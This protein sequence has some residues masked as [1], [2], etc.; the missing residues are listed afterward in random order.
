M[1]IISQPQTPNKDN[2]SRF[3]RFTFL[4][5]QIFRTTYIGSQFLRRWI[6]SEIV[7]PFPLIN[8]CAQGCVSVGRGT[9]RECIEFKLY[10]A[11]SFD[12]LDKSI[13][14][15]CEQD[16]V[17]SMFC[18]LSIS[19]VGAPSVPGAQDMWSS[20]LVPSL[21]TLAC[22]LVTWGRSCFPFNQL[23]IKLEDGDCLGLVFGVLIVFVV[24]GQI[25]LCTGV[26]GGG[27]LGLEVFFGGWRI[28]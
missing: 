13:S 26:F 21:C 24:F 4:C 1:S 20:S 27:F 10:I 6:S 11:R 18:S 9:G 5:S 25:F 17:L 7:Q 12:L 28:T 22:S 2:V 14:I 16:M 19:S 15:I 8:L 23:V 3:F